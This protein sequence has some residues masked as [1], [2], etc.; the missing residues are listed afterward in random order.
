MPSW[1][2]RLN[3]RRSL[4]QPYQVT[5]PTLSGHSPN[6]IRSRAQLRWIKTSKHP[7]SSFSSLG[8]GS[9]ND[10]IIPMRASAP[11]TMA[12]IFQPPMPPV[13]T[14]SFDAARGMIRMESSIN[15]MLPGIRF[16]RTQGGARLPH[17]PGMVF[18]GP[19]RRRLINA[20]DLA[21]DAHGPIPK[22]GVRGV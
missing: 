9:Q 20:C 6:P 10:R 1:A 16:R 21:Y 2:C 4:T 11:A 15:E 22:F 13:L 14:L 17:H 18:Q 12:P 7:C 19:Q 5:H 8:S 3:L